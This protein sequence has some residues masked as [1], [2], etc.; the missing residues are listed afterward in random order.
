MSMLDSHWL[1]WSRTAFAVVFA[2]TAAVASSCGTRSDGEPQDDLDKY[3][4]RDVATAEAGGVHV[5]WLGREFTAGDLVFR[6]PYGAEFGAE[7]EGGGVHM[8]YLAP[9]DGKGNTGLDLI[10]YGRNA[11]TQAEQRITNP[12]IPGELRPV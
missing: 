1:D 8:T 11:W 5:Y 9:V 6:G 3:F 2:L 4:R 10:L 12:K 7:V